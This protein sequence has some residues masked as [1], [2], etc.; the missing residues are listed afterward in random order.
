SGADVT[1]GAPG[2]KKALV[3]PFFVE[4]QDP[5]LEDVATEGIV[6]TVG[7]DPPGHP[8][9]GLGRRVLLSEEGAAV[10]LNIDLARSN[11]Q[12]SPAWPILLSNLVRRAGHRIA[13][14]SQRHLLLGEE[15]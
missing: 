7:D 1:L 13:G 8:L 3:G 2:E 14:F 10:H 6:W 11:L 5:L 4:K 12:R 9:I 15:V